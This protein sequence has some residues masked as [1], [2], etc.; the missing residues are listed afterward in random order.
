VLVSVSDKTNLEM[1]AKVW[2]RPPLLGSLWIAYCA[3]LMR[4]LV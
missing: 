4:A 3:K 1:L 2:R